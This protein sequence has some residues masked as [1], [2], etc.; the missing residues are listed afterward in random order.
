MARSV[1]VR[2]FHRLTQE[3]L[4]IFLDKAADILYGNVDHSEFRGYVFALL[5][6]KRISD[7]YVEEVRKIADTYHAWRGAKD[8]RV[9]YEDIPGFCK[10]ATT[11]EILKH[12]YV[13]TPG[14]YVGAAPQEEDDE[15]FDE[16]MR[17]LVGQLREQQA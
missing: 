15:P 4:D 1:T 14:R 7:G 5:F 13:L 3:E 8:C 17:R 9:K 2:H 10:S 12:D 6:F 11:E 16:K